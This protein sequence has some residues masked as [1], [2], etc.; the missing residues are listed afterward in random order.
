[1]PI[2]KRIKQNTRLPPAA[3]TQPAATMSG[4]IS[5]EQQD[6]LGRLF[7]R[8][9][10]ETRDFGGSVPGPSIVN[11]TNPDLPTTQAGAA[12]SDPQADMLRK[13]MEKR[14]KE[15]GIGVH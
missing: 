6:V 5:G 14:A 9:Q 13:L 15:L 10:P 12:L 11:G 1:M 8:R 2:T 3:M 7:V 4:D